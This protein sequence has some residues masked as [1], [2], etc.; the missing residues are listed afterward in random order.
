MKEQNEGKFQCPGWSGGASNLSPMSEITKER[1]HKFGIWQTHVMLSYN[2][3][4]ADND[5]FTCA[6]KTNHI[7]NR[8][9]CTNDIYKCVRTWSHG[10]TLRYWCVPSQNDHMSTSWK[11]VATI[12]NNKVYTN[13]PQDFGGWCIVSHGHDQHERLGLG[14][15]IN[16]W[17]KMG[18][19]QAGTAGNRSSSRFLAAEVQGQA[20][21]RWTLMQRRWTLV[22]SHDSS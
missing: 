9:L 1:I 4:V 11:Y 13:I 15:T 8:I 21:G 22:W 12:L 17:E 2:W 18:L 10:V 5:P 6:L 7:F 19:S 16:H 3:T 14:H 20:V